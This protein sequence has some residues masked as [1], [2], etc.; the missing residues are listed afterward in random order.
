MSFVDH[1]RIR[2]RAGDGGR[3]AASFLR[4]KL[5]AKGGPNGG[6]GGRGG[7][8]ILV[9]EPGLASLAP[10]VRDRTHRVKSAGNGG[11]HNRDGAD[12]DDLLLRVP[13]GTIVRDAATEEVLADLAKPGTRYVLARGGRGGRGNASLKSPTDRI[14]NYAESGEPGEEREVALELHLVA[15]VGLLGPPNAGKSTLLSAISRANPKIADYPFTTI[16]PGL[17][18]MIHGPG[19]AGGLPHDDERLTVAD[20]PGLIEGASQGRGLGLRFLRHADRCA[21]LAFVVDLAGA[22][23]VGDLEAVA[24]EVESYDPELAERIRVVVGNKTDLV[25]ADVSGASRWAEEHG[26]RFVAVS[27][28]EGSNL[29]ELRTAFVEEVTRAREE[30]GTPGSFVV[31]RPVAEDRV[32]VVR[33]DSAFRVSSDRVERMVAQTPLDNPRAV[34]RLQRRLRALGVENA[35]AREGAKEGDEVRIGNTAFEWF[36]DQDAPPRA[37]SKHA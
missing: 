21:L 7:S 37:P 1:V 30:L 11:P 4:T 34:R 25:G 5:E 12:S 15:D 16:E 22:D 20:L 29:D 13:V 14:P 3:G 27:A 33:E 17:G 24:G 10:Y 23:P 6:N 18:V 2:V 28:A 9:A 19:G 32:V 26:A 8:V 31:Y 35:L 36:P